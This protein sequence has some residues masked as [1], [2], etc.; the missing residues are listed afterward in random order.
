MRPIV[1]EMCRTGGLVFLNMS[2]PVAGWS[3]S[4]AV[5]W[6]VADLT[7]LDGIVCGPSPYAWVKSE[8]RDDAD[9]NATPGSGSKHYQRRDWEPIYCFALEDRLP[10]PG[11]DFWSDNTAFGK[12]PAYGAGGEFSTRTVDGSR[13]NDPW[14]TASR[15]GSGCGGRRPNG[16]KMQGPLANAPGTSRRAN[17]ERKAVKRDQLKRTAISCG[18]D[19]NGDM[20]TED[21]YLPPPIS[22]PGNVI[23]APVGGGKLGHPLAHEGEAPMSLFV[24]ERFVCWFAPPNSIVGDPFTGTGTTPH[25]AKLHGRR[26][27]GCDV[28]QSQVDLTTRRMAT[29]TPSLFSE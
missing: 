15:G 18:H 11:R 27:I 14:K 8:N 4:P 28:R 25:A 7:R 2:S 6:L 16:S 23:R 26:F 13:V 12:P 24:A 22:N 1:C 19:A 3:Y 10:G 29:V 20:A 9:G 21:A 5:E 17:G